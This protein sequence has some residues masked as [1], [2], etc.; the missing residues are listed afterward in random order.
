M[1][2]HREIVASSSGEKHDRSGGLSFRQKFL[3]SVSPMTVQPWIPRLL[4]VQA[5]DPSPGHRASAESSRLS[6]YVPNEGLFCIGRDWMLHIVSGY[7]NSNF[8]QVHG[9]AVDLGNNCFFH[10][11]YFAQYDNLWV[12]PASCQWHVFLLFSGWIAF[13][14]RHVPHFLGPLSVDGCYGCFQVV[15]V[16][17]K[18]SVLDHSKVLMDSPSWRSSS[19]TPH[20]L[21][22]SLCLSSFP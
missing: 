5:G 11:P 1:D 8:I 20:W 10:L 16:V 22:H 9:D 13:P 15:A 2:P 19:G 18:A 14:L 21:S 12:C 6:I 7:R 17:S 3:S 4:G